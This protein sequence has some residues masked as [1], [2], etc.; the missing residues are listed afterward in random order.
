MIDGVLFMLTHFFRL[1]VWPTRLTGAIAGCFDPMF[2][3]GLFIAYRFQGT[4][5]ITGL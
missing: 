1:T 4:L 5:G 3:C 2:F